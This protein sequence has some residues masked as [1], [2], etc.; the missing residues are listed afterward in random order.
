VSDVSPV[1]RAVSMVFAFDAAHPCLSLTELARRTSLPL[2]T[3]HRLAGQLVALSVLDRDRDGR[4]TVGRRLWDIGLLSPIHRE[5]REAALPFLRDVFMVT[6]ANVHLAIRDGR[7]TLF[8]ERLTTQQNSS[9]VSR[10]GSR[11]PLYATGVG[12][13]MLAFAPEEV[14]EDALVGAR[15]LTKHTVVDRLRLRAELAEV[16]RCGFARTREETLPGAAAIGVPILDASEMAV[17][18]IGIA[19][20]GGSRDLSALAPVLQVAARGIARRLDPLAAVAPTTAADPTARLPVPC[21]ESAA[22]ARA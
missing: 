15:P 9:L 3:T 6:Q 21:Q 1:A 13:A 20:S 5:L 14:V 12:K 19:T 8:V 10:A 16:R 11:L 17:A 18:A 7:F 2:S 4:F 22:G